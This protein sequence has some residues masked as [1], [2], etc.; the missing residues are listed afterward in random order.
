MD[1]GPAREG[2]TTGRREARL[3][4]TPSD[5]VHSLADQFTQVRGLSIAPTRSPLPVASLLLPSVVIYQIHA[6]GLIGFEPEHHAP[7]GP[8]RERSNCPPD[9]P[10]NGDSLKPGAFRTYR[11]RGFL[12]PEQGAP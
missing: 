3:S 4:H 6:H 2:A 1:H 10:S 7:S 5:L 11:V 9:S 8:R 12:Q